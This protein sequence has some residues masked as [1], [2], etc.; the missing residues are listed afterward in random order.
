MTT[1]RTSPADR[2]LDLIADS[3]LGLTREHLGSLGVKGAV[4]DKLVA[5]GKVEA[6]LHRLANPPI[7]VTRYHAVMPTGEDHHARTS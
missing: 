2:A 3:S 5:A 4:L 6:K 1:K 7:S